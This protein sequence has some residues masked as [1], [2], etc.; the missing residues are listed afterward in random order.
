MFS[1]GSDFEGCNSRMCQTTSSGGGPR[2]ASMAT[3]PAKTSS[4]RGRLYQDPGSSSGR[5][6]RLQGWDSLSGSHAKTNAWS[7]TPAEM[8]TPRPIGGD[9]GAHPD[10]MPFLRDDHGRLREHGGFT[11]SPPRCMVWYWSFLGLVF[12]TFFSINASKMQ[13]FFRF[14]K[15][16][17]LNLNLFHSRVN[18]D[19]YHS[20]NRLFL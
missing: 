10:R 4:S 1:C 20:S 9:D 11:N 8:S 3:G 13:S 14:R 2:T 12:I 17:K 16:K 6:R 5:P 7:S 15:E 19:A 18:Q